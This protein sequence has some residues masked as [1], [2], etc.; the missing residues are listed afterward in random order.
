[1]IENSF[2]ILVS[3]WR[4]LR[5]P[6]ALKPKSVD[7]IVLTTI[8]LHNFLKTVNDLNPANERI[9][10]TPNFIDTKQEDG[11]IIPGAWRYE[12]SGNNMECIRPSTAHRSTQAAYK[13]RNEIPDYLITS[14]GEVPWQYDYIHR[15]F[16]GPDL[17]DT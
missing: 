8:C 6:I 2:G 1:V 4:V 12:N 9:Y 11:D 5:K 16:N 17:I 13:Q 7:K 15:G 10:Y 3:R 14:N